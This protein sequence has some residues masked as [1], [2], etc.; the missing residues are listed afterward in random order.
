MHTYPYVTALQ[1][2]PT[3]L[4]KALSET[5]GEDSTAPHYAF[6]D[7]PTLIPS[8]TNMRRTAFLSR[9]MGRR[10]AR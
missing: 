10:A 6:I 5:V 3:D 8:Q 2:G 1:R 4:L 9:E 7:D